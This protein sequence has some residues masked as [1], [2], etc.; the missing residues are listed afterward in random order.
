M[1]SVEAEAGIHYKRDVMGKPAEIEEKR[2]DCV[3]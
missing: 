3:L 2:I 1:A